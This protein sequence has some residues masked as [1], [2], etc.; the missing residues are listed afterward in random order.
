MA[1]RDCGVIHEKDN[2]EDFG[3]IGGSFSVCH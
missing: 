3:R 2:F 1:S